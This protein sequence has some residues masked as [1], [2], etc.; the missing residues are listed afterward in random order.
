M[1]V[2]W[3]VV[4]VTTLALIGR[5]AQVT[6]WPKIVWPKIVWPKIVWRCRGSHAIQS[7]M[8][9]GRTVTDDTV[10]QKREDLGS[11]SA[12]AGAWTGGRRP[13]PGTGCPA[14]SQ[15]LSPAQPGSNAPPSRARPGRWRCS[16]GRCTTSSRISARQRR[17]SSHRKRPVA[18][19]QTVATCPYSSGA[20][21]P[22]SRNISRA[23]RDQ[24][25]GDVIRCT[26]SQARHVRG[27]RMRG[28]IRVVHCSPPDRYRWRSGERLR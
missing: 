12:G 8:P 15:R 24:C 6:V 7:E 25:F 4:H 1:V 5:G 27:R 11:T 26:G 3:C 19:G 28:M 13:R 16:G 9:C 17:T 22:P 23:I 2:G 20:L 21:Q 10:R 18:P 14:L